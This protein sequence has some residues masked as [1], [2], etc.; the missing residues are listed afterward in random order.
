MINIE[1]N[2]FEYIGATLIA[3]FC[4]YNIIRLFSKIFNTVKMFSVSKKTRKYNLAKY[5]TTRREEF[6]ER[7]PN[8]T[9]DE[10]KHA[11]S[12]QII[13]NTWKDILVY[14]CISSIVTAVSTMSILLCIETVSLFIVSA[15]FWW[16][17]YNDVKFFKTFKSKYL[18]SPF[19]TLSFQVANVMYLFSTLLI[20]VENVYHWI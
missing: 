20:I 12:V 17:A 1:Y 7:K 3:A 11:E 6:M 13:S 9:L 14:T 8:V 4:A 2:I 5:I 18:T 10:L 15:G 16:A 19:F